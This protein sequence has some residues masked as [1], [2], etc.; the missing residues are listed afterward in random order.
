VLHPWLNTAES[1]QRILE[2]RALAGQH[3]QTLR[4]TL[5]W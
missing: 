2:R 1:V 4:F 5:P 3:P